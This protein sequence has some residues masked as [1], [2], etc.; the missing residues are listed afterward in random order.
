MT[1]KENN[2]KVITNKNRFYIN[3]G[4]VTP[5]PA[6]FELGDKQ[7]NDFYS[8]CIKREGCEKEECMWRE[9]GPVSNRKGREDQSVVNGRIS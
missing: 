6:C 9:R 1:K 2:N 4:Q 8:V 3:N 5:R 7:K